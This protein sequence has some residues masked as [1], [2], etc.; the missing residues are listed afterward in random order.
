ME[1]SSSTRNDSPE[2]LRPK[3]KNNST[4]KGKPTMKNYL[5]AAAAARSSNPPTKKQTPVHGELLLGRDAAM[6]AANQ[7]KNGNENIYAVLNP[8]NARASAV[9]N[10][11]FNGDGDAAPGAAAAA[12]PSLTTRNM[13]ARGKKEK[14]E[15]LAQE[16]RKAYQANNEEIDN[17]FRTFPNEKM[18]EILLE[19]GHDTKEKELV[20]VSIADQ[21][22]NEKLTLLQIFQKIYSLGL[23]SDTT[24][25]RFND[26]TA[27][28]MALFSLLAILQKGLAKRMPDSKIKDLVRRFRYLS[29][30]KRTFSTNIENPDHSRI[31]LGY[32]QQRRMYQDSIEGTVLFVDPLIQTFLNEEIPK[33]IYDY[34]FPRSLSHLNDQ[35]LFIQ[36]RIIPLL[37]ET[38][39]SQFIDMRSIV[40]SLYKHF[41]WIYKKQTKQQRELRNEIIQ[42]RRYRQLGLEGFGLEHPSS[43]N[44][45]RANTAIAPI[46]NIKEYSLDTIKPIL[47]K[48]DTI[49]KEYEAN[50]RNYSAWDKWSLGQKAFFLISSVLQLTNGA[51]GFHNKVLENTRRMELREAEW[52]REQAQRQ[53][54]QAERAESM[55][56][57]VPGE[58][59]YSGS[60]ALS[61]VLASPSKVVSTI[62]ASAPQDFLTEALAEE[63]F[64]KQKKYAQRAEAMRY[65][66]PG[67]QEK[68]AK[69]EEPI[70][71]ALNLQDMLAERLAEEEW[72]GQQSILSEAIKLRNEAAAACE[73]AQDLANQDSMTRIG[74]EAEGTTCTASMIAAHAAS[75]VIKNSQ[76]EKH[77]RILKDATEKAKK[78]LEVVKKAADVA[79]KHAA[80]RNELLDTLKESNLSSDGIIP[81]NTEFS[82]VTNTV[83]SHM[84][85]ERNILVKRAAA[86]IIDVN[87]Q[88]Q[89]MCNNE[90]VLKR[91]FQSECGDSENTERNRQSTQNH[92]NDAASIVNNS[93][94]KL[95]E[96][97][98]KEKTIQDPLQ[99]QELQTEV[100]LLS[101]AV[102]KGLKDLKTAEENIQNNPE[103]LSLSPNDFDTFLVSQS[104]VENDINTTAANVTVIESALENQADLG[105]EIQGAN[106]LVQVKEQSQTTSDFREAK[107][108]AD[109]AV[110]AA[111]MKLKV[112]NDQELQTLTDSN[113]RLIPAENVKGKTSEASIAS[114]RVTLAALPLVKELENEAKLSCIKAANALED[115]VKEASRAIG[116]VGIEVVKQIANTVTV[117]SEVAAAAANDAYQR[118]TQ[119]QGYSNTAVNYSQKTKELHKGPLRMN[120]NVSQAAEASVMAEKSALAIKVEAAHAGVSK[121]AARACDYA[122]QA[123]VLSVKAQELLK[124]NTNGNVKHIETAQKSLLDD[125]KNKAVNLAKEAVKM[126]ETP[127]LRGKNWQEKETEAK[128]LAQQTKTALEEAVNDFNKLLTFLRVRNTTGGKQRKT[129]KMKG[130]RV[131]PAKGVN[132]IR[133]EP[134]TINALKKTPAKQTLRKNLNTQA[135]VETLAKTLVTLQSYSPMVIADMKLKLAARCLDELLNILK[136]KKVE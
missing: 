75:R 24:T 80:V 18:G 77:S 118:A 70:N 58:T 84:Q 129:R 5:T 115:I 37:Y 125:K 126:I 124:K 83:M 27:H 61:T 88:R 3:S 52:Q 68:P 38:G 29:Q 71:S 23:T 59:P 97:I 136:T 51:I 54:E 132:L 50:T 120:V 102:I 42:S 12:A 33:A 73:N 108:K 85:K 19:E 105:P 78:G 87:T 82:I 135:K 74:F 63:E 127:S 89:V 40:I 46:E 32:S 107:I 130:G 91:I 62:F 22:N 94:Q 44:N 57:F 72:T 65:F 2:S 56:Y 41:V 36:G 112:Y 67:Q 86:A 106:I 116:E 10:Q 119:A 76:N 60:K 66:A 98:D 64:A 4:R 30:Y 134:F 53:K 117:E 95:H 47:E 128:V 6:A 103:K 8:T 90:S 92:F 93:I 123:V 28:T 20:P 31:L 113:Y 49:F 133:S 7:I 34:L 11:R 25:K 13:E 101:S 114:S 96:A 1:F 79:N 43:R 15:K 9:A 35:N 17:F 110:Q 131:V 121:A 69:K 45:S 99:K 39:L 109:T 26:I 111:A 14:I 100:Y 55:R 81:G 104:P 122:A 16:I 21:A 48:L